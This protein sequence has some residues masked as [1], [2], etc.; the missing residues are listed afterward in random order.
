MA[1]KLSEYSGAKNY[2]RTKLE[3]LRVERDALSI[4]IGILEAEA[5]Q[6]SSEKRAPHEAGQ[7]LGNPCRKAQG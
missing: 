3:C 4:L 5:I 6:V 1:N 7:G 2:P